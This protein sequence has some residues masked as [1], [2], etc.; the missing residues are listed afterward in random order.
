MADLRSAV[1]AAGL[2]LL[3]LVPWSQRSLVADLAPAVLADVQRVY[4]GVSLE[5]LLATFVAV[6][7]RRPVSGR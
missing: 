4:P 5:D 1:D 6:I 3:A 2:E 7:A